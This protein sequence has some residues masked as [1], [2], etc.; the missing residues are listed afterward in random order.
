MRFRGGAVCA[1]SAAQTM[2]RANNN[3][4]SSAR[5]GRV[6]A[7]LPVPMGRPRDEH[8]LRTPEIQDYMAHLR[9]LL[10]HREAA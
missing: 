4:D 2:T 1:K 3:V 6:I 10:I 7:D 9:G 5:P 8:S